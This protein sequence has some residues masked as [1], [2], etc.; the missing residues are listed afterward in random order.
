MCVSLS[1]AAYLLLAVGIPAFA[2][3]GKPQS[4]AASGRTRAYRNVTGVMEPTLRIGQTVEVTLF[5]DSANAAATVRHADLVLYAWPV[6]TS[7]HFIKRLVGLPGDTL[8]MHGGLLHRNGQPV[9]ESYV[10]HDDTVAAAPLPELEWSRRFS[11]AGHDLPTLS[12]NAWGPRT[13]AARVERDGAH[14]VHGVE[15][16]PLLAQRVILRLQSVDL[17]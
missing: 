5:D 17:P 15:A 6:D 14:V 2:A 3:C 11:I 9:T 12:R 10:I 8:A 7:K 16:L 1:R 13:L 4:A